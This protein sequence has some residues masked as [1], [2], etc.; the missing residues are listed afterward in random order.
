MYVSTLWGTFHNSVAR[1][2]NPCFRIGEDP[3]MAMIF[4]LVSKRTSPGAGFREMWLIVH[5]KP[6]FVLEVV[7]LLPRLSRNR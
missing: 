4:S 2:T 5:R 7:P 3:F 1:E 6:Y